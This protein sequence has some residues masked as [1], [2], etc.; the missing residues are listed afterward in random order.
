LLNEVRI[1]TLNA[2]C[3]TVVPSLERE[4]D[5]NGFW[6]RS[7]RDVGANEAVAK[8]IGQMPAADQEGLDELLDLL[9]LQGF[10]GLSQASREQVLT[11][12]SLAS[13]EAAVGIGGLIGLTLFFTYGLPPNPA[14]EQFAYPGPTSPPPAVEKPITPLSP[15]DGEVIEAD[16][17]IVGSGAGGGVIAARLAEAG[18]KV[19]VLEAGEYYNE[20]DFDQTELNGF[21]RMYWR[22]GP[23]Y[24]ADYNVSLQAGTCLGGGT[25]VNWT[26]CLKPKPWVRKEWADEHGLTDVDTPEFDQHIESIW[27][28]LG[29]NDQCSELNPSHQTWIDAAESLGWSWKT[30]DRNWDP[31]KHDPR[32]AGL[33]G[34]G[35]QSGA[36]QSTLKTYL[37][38][39]VDAGADV[40]VNCTAEK[41]LT[42][43][44]KA[45]GIQ[46]R[47]GET[48]VT[49]KA[50]RVVVAC[51]ALESP[52]LLLRSGIGGPAVGKYLR[53]H[54]CTLIFADYGSDQKTWWGAPHAAIIDEFAAGQDDDGYGYLIEGAQYTTGLGAS[55]IPFTTAEEHK[56]V[57]AGYS[58]GITTI[59]LIRDVG[60]GQV[61]I[62]EQG[63]SVPLYSLTE[64]RDIRNMRHALKQQVRLHVAAG[65][66][67][68]Y[69]LATGLPEWRV[70]D[71]VEAFIERSSRIPLRAGGARL[72]SAH[73]MGT[74]R[75]GENPETSVADPRGE[76]HD[77]PGVWIGDGSAFPT[78]SGTNPMIT[79]MSLASRTAAKMLEVSDHSPTSQGANPETQTVA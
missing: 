37:Q 3:D 64:P 65:A 26:N 35:D 75:M 50:P 18:L 15:A 68:I 13:R 17:V 28:R 46:A 8:A 7:A 10:N 79:I 61:V 6:A 70:G 20:A 24:T 34:W 48:D 23:T 58:D 30:V 54:P 9:A 38:D 16:A 66:R 19:I 14:W 36:K 41:V 52:A 76:L 33:M 63:Q 71:D 32:V 62:D 53:L 42:E 27:K 1:E 67:R 74:C 73:Q 25:V 12:M 57:L 44:G 11:N 45:A 43:D 5:D 51:G 56:E 49:I 21:A 60:H 39:A 59:S 40:I 22:G 47:F 77:T 29:V 31:E 55:A 2:V 78:P 69:V 72:F 4:G